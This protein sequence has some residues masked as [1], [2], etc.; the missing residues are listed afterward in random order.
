MIISF[1]DFIMFAVIISLNIYYWNK[2]VKFGF[3]KL[4]LYLALFLL[5][6]PLVSI[7]I[8]L[9]KAPSHSEGFNLL[10]TLIKFPLYWGL[11]TLQALTALIRYD[12]KGKKPAASTGEKP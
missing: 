12:Q 2:Y 10:Y 11:L 7:E 4:I 8:E 6:L 3:W 9:M 1:F 5:F